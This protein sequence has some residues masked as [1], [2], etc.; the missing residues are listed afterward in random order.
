MD[1]SIRAE[2][3]KNK[4]TV[5]TTVVCPYYINTGMFEGVKTRFPL[6]LPIL[7]EKV[8]V[9]KIV[10]AIRKN[11]TRQGVSLVPASN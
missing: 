1:E 2:L 7:N 8:V 3:K 10:R 9:D 6:L 11:K 4:S 5:K